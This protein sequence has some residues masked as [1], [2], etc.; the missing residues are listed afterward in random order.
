MFHLGTEHKLSKERDSY[1]RNTVLPLWQLKENLEFRLS[2]MQCYLSEGSA[3]KSKISPD[4]MLRQVG[5]LTSLLQFM[6]P[7]IYTTVYIHIS[8]PHIYTTVYITAIFLT[9]SFMSPFESITH[10][11]VTH[12]PV[13]ALV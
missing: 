6:T 1:Q 12:T 4:E 11:R 2:E 3:L 10:V 8:I 5:F 9:F 13:L 7:I